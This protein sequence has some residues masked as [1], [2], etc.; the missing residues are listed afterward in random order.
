[1]QR[2][3]RVSRELSSWSWIVIED[4]GCQKNKSRLNRF[5]PGYSAWVA[6]GNKKMH[7][8]LLASGPGAYDPEIWGLG[9]QRN[10]RVIIPQLEQHTIR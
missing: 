7:V 5:V 8:L 6:L 9:R 1:M 4:G 2:E 10:T 3:E